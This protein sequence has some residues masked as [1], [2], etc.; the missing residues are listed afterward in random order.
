[1]LRECGITQVEIVGSSGDGGIDGTGQLKIHGL[2]SFKMAFQCKKYSGTV[3][4]NHIRDFRGSMTTD[5]EKGLFI[6]TGTFTRDAIREASTPGKKT[7]DLVNGD[8]LIDKLA[9]LELG[10]KPIKAYEINEE[11]FR[12]I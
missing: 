9:E 3:S 8:E 2:I 5:V 4:S 1:L 12:N 6:T 7:I 10:L 11:F